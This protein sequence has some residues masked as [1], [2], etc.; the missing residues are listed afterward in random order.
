MLWGVTLV[1]MSATVYFTSIGLLCFI[2]GAFEASVTPGFALITS[3][4][5]TKQEQGLRTAAWYCSASVSS[6]LGGLFAY[7]VST[8]WGSADS[9]NWRIIF[10]F[11]G[12]VTVLVGTGFFYLV[13]DS[14]LKARFQDNDDKKSAIERIRS[15]QQ[16][17]LVYPSY[18]NGP[19]FSLDSIPMTFS[20]ALEISISNHIKSRCVVIISPS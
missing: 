11:W 4:W 19:H 14:P 15:N 10:A 6:V 12:A 17:K 20:K 3:Q 5:Y 8:K 2:L 7:S 13:P 1:C 9:T 16:G 18:N